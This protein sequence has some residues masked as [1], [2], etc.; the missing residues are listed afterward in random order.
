[1][2]AAR[3]RGH[4]QR[5]RRL[6]HHDRDALGVCEALARR[7]RRAR[8]ASVADDRSQLDTHVLPS[9]GAR[10][11]RAITRDDLEGLVEELDGKVRAGT[12]SWK[13]A[14]H[15][16]G[17]VTRMF[18][19]ASGAKRRTSVFARTAQRKGST[20]RTEARASRRFTCTPRSSPPLC[21][22]RTSRTAGDACS[23]S[24]RASTR[25]LGT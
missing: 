5:Q 1:M 6:R 9:L 19:D 4:S 24:R 16:W 3:E 25:E 10:D 23:R 7:A 22:A 13:T 2:C 21:R 17:V 15:A 20:L 12:I 18:A 14:T 11:V 8:A